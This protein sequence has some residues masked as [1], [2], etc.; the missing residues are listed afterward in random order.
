MVVATCDCNIPFRTLVVTCII[1]VAILAAAVAIPVLTA[2]L[3]IATPAEIA[4][5]PA[6]AVTSAVKA[7]AVVTIAI[8]MTVKV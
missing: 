6:N 5:A 3:I 7:A 1:P 2:A 4:C 8:R